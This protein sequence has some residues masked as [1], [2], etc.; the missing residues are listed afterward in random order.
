ME[1]FFGDYLAYVGESEAPDIFHRWVGISIVGTLLGRDYFLNFGLVGDIFPNQYVILQGD[2]GVR[3]GTAL[4][5]GTNLLKK[6]GYDKFAPDRMSRQAFLDEMHRLNAPP[7]ELGALLDYI[8]GEAVFEMS[9]HASEFID[10][11]GQQDK[12]YLMLLTKLWD[13]E[14]EY[15]NPKISKHSVTVNKPTVNMLAANTPEALA[16]AFPPST[17][18]T[19]T[20]SRIIFVHSPP[21]G[22]KILIPPV[23]NKAL[24]EGLVNHL[25]AIKAGVKGPANITAEAMEALSYIYAKQLPLSDP[26]F[27]HY[28]ERRIIHLLK[29][30]LI[31]SAMRI[32]TTITEA[33]VLE[34]NTI[35]GMTEYNMPAALGHF[36]RS[37][38]SVTMHSVLEWVRKQKGLVTYPE[39]FKRFISDFNGEKDFQSSLMDLQQSSKL[40]AVRDG[41]NKFAGFTTQDDEFPKWLKELMIVDKLTSQERGMIG[42]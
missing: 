34:A 41:D 18:S 40:V 38:Q 14:P 22:K 37:R 33:D 12:D 24:E 15:A 11:I 2:P 27:S 5:I 30:C 16:L 39:I 25:T 1:G 19:G 28:N 29:L 9:I 32:S 13:N 20:F 31:C 21:T 35:L 42:L 8:P 3:K 7:T 4:R 17:V 23:P 36:G 6:V 10:F 26:R